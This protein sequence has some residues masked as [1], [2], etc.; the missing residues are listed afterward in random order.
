VSLIVIR[1]LAV[2]RAYGQHTDH[3]RTKTAPFSG[4]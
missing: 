2:I 4:R 3:N 1:S